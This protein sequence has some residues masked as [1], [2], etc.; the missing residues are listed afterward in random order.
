MDT[1][2]GNRF[3]FCAECLGSFITDNLGRSENDEPLPLG[4]TVSLAPFVIR[5]WEES[6]DLAS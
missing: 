1:R 5:G 4:F 3:D 6:A 2:W